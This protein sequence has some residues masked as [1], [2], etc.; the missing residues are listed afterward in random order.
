LSSIK[1]D[2]IRWL[3][4]S[5]DL[6]SVAI[7]R[8]A[9]IHTVGTYLSWCQDASRLS[10]LPLKVQSLIQ[11]KWAS[12]HRSLNNVNS[13]LLRST[14]VIAPED[15]PVSLE[16]KNTF[17]TWIVVQIWRDWLSSRLRTINGNPSAEEVGR[18]YLLLNCPSDTYLTVEYVRA[19]L[20]YVKG[21]GFGA[22]DNLAEDLEIL[23]SFARNI[24]RDICIN[25]SDL[26][27][28]EEGIK[29]LTC[30]NVSNDE[31]PWLRPET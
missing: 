12:L 25:N 13:T 6:Q 23:K 15:T 8:E 4:I 2:P 7:F 18:L 21:D 1:G 22:F 17:E 3:K 26:N 24:V 5:I 11:C 16:H 30:T 29:Y 28:E 31:I 19:L 10:S 14:I 9:V 27:V 20:E